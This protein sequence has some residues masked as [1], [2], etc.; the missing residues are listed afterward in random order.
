MSPRV[1]T[2]L[3]LAVQAALI[4]HV[5]RTGRNMIWIL[6]IALLPPL[7][8]IAYLGV[9]VLPG[10]FGG[11]RGQRASRL[12]RRVIDPD[13]E[14]RRASA[15]VEISG[16]VDA[17]RRLGDELIERGQFERA[18]EVYRGGLKG[19]FEHDPTLLMGLARALFAR[20]E[21]AAA[22]TALEDLE[23]YNPE[24]QFVDAGL[25]HARTL[26][27]LGELEEAEKRYEAV[28][29]V[30]PGAEARLRWALLLK[31]RGNTVEARRIL[32]D[33]LESAQLGPA[34]FRRSQAEWLDRARRELG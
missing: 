29:P 13:R 12:V 5:I 2:F 28:A 21:Y 25:L 14:L 15:E 3:I 7:G 31:R 8:P 16:N 18:I 4:A 33:L 19:V 32:K 20:Q 17:R 6:V 11:R 26:E 27:A 9:E 22:R 24:M 23:R 30:F 34:H 10:L 1:V